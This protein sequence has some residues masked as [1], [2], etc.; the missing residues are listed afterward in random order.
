MNYKLVNVC[1]LDGINE[2]SVTISASLEL[3]LFLRQLG[4][5]KFGITQ[6]I[7]V[8]DIVNYG[9]IKVL[10]DESIYVGGNYKL[11]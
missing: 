10:Q 6:V 11:S 4:I 2:E 3:A 7:Q 9:D 5:L 8:S 1:P